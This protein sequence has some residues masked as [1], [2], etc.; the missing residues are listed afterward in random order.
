V[1]PWLTADEAAAYA[2]CS[3]KTIS[4]AAARGDLRAVRL[5][6][7]HRL[8]LR[9]EWLDRWLDTDAPD[10]TSGVGDGIS[11]QLRATQAER[12][13]KETVVIQ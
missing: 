8:R 2:K 7:S 11:G 12:E 3:T 6:G 1:T 9:R 13:G 5:S 10:A 4:R